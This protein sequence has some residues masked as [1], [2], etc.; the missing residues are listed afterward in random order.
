MQ[1]KTADALN[2]MAGVLRQMLTVQND[3]KLTMTKMLQLQ[4][5]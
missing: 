5:N 4:R 3:Q 2:N 1:D